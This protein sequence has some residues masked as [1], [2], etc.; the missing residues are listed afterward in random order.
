LI[1]SIDLLLVASINRRNAHQLHCA[2]SAEELGVDPLVLRGTHRPGKN[3]HAGF[4]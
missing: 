1:D 2:R 4:T 3:D